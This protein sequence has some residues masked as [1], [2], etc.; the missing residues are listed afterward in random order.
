M[1]I[2]RRDVGLDLSAVHNEM[3]RRFSGIAADLKRL[4]DPG[5]S[6]PSSQ[7]QRQ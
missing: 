1:T 6:A 7:V 5:Y 2:Q 4:L 3:W